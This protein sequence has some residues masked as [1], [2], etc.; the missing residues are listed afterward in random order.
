MRAPGRKRRHEAV[1]PDAR[2]EAESGGAHEGT[3]CVHPGGGGAP[4]IHGEYGVGGLPGREPGRVQIGD[5]VD[6]GMLP[7]EGGL[8]S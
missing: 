5:H 6:L 8:H 4:R 7:F 2:L 3:P 1:R